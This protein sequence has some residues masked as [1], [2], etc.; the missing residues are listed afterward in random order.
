MNKVYLL[1]L[2]LA[3]SSNIYAIDLPTPQKINLIQA[4]EYSIN[5]S[6][7]D[8]NEN[9]VYKIYRDEVP[10]G[11]TQNSSFKDISLI[12]NKNYSYQIS[13]VEN[14]EESQKSQPFQFSTNSN[15]TFLS[16]NNIPASSGMKFKYFDDGVEAAFN[17]YKKLIINKYQQA[18]VAEIINKMCSD[19]DEHW[20]DI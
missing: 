16:I 20:Y 17:A 9:A 6:W 15:T 1:S 10:V 12:P 2:L 14:N 11:L 3:F 13:V 7:D 4:K 5:L 18:P 19:F 8:N